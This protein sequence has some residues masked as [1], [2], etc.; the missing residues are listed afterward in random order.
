LTSYEQPGLFPEEEY[1][2][3]G[4]P[5]RATRLQGI[6]AAWLTHAQDCGGTSCGSWMRHAPVGSLAKT[7]LGSLASTAAGTSEPS[8]VTWMTSGTAWRGEF[9]M[10]SGSESPSGAAACSLPDVLET[11][12]H[13][14]RYYLSPKAAAGILRRA[15]KRGQTLPPALAA[16]LETLAGTPQAA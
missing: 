3:P 12:P 13:L 11:G 6:A 2:R 4:G 15:A 16:A 1:S 8:C 10:L 5:A 14:S 7:W 9:W